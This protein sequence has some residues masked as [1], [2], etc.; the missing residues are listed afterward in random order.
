VILENIKH[1]Q[2]EKE[3]MVQLKR[4][5]RIPNWNTLCRW[6]LVASLAEKSV[7]PESRLASD[8][9]IEMSWRVFGGEHSDVYEALIRQRCLED[10]LGTAQ[11]TL[12]KYFRLH[13]HRGIGYLFADR[14]I[15]SIQQLVR[16][17]TSPSAATTG[18][19]PHENPTGQDSAEES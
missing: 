10:G 8:S 14:S 6:A 5:T 3:H 2:R 11:E 16:R 13:L 17:A 19:L 9:S 15:Q 1:S 12:A 7:P 18:A 4:R